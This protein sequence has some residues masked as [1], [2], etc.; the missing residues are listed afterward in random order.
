MVLGLYRPH[1]RKKGM[2]LY[3]STACKLRLFSTKEQPYQAG[4]DWHTSQPYCSIQSLFSLA[5][6]VFASARFHCS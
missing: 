3:C 2:R 6:A 4:E 5:Y 1:H